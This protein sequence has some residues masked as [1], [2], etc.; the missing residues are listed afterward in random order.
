MAMMITQMVLLS[1]ILQRQLLFIVY[2]FRGADDA[3]I[4]SCSSA[5]RVDC[6]LFIYY[7]YQENLL[8]PFK[9]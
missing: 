2:T 1:K 6:S 9:L 4:E 5:C 3:C 7:E 8:Q